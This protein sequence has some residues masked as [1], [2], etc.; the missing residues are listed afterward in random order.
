MKARAGRPAH[1]GKLSP[2]REAIAEKTREAF[3]RAMDAVSDED[4]Y[5]AERM[6]GIRLGL[7]DLLEKNKIKQKDLAVALN[8]TESAVSRLINSIDF[9]PKL[10][11][12]LRIEKF[13]NKE[14]ISI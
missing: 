5:V 9:N 10:D 12:L 11:T 4:L 8:T 6:I 7:I 3:Q 14:F 1:I 2:E 13:L